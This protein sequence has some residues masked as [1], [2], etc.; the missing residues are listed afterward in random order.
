MRDAKVF[1]HPAYYLEPEKTEVGMAAD[2][3]E[4]IAQTFRDINRTRRDIYKKYQDFSKTI[5]ERSS[6]EDKVQHLILLS[7]AITRN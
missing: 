4:D 2:R 7:N 5:K 3:S 6:L 1:A